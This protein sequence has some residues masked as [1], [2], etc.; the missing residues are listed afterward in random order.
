MF[1]VV[2]VVSEVNEPS[3]VVAHSQVGVEHHARFQEDAEHSRNARA[4][5]RRQLEVLPAC[6]ERKQRG[7]R[8]ARENA[9]DDLSRIL[10]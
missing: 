8:V 3:R 4:N 6:R 10:Q 7:V 5:A 1:R 9:G 2:R